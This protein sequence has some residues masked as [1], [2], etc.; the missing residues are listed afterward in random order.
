M[1]RGRHAQDLVDIHTADHS[2][3]AGVTFWPCNIA[4]L[5]WECITPTAKY[6]KDSAAPG[7]SYP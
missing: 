5:C 2:G 1:G 7:S 6:W 3:F 4:S